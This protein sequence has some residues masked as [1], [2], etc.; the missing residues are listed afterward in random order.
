MSGAS[1]LY[2]SFSDTD[3]S[4]ADVVFIDNIQLSANIGP[5]WWGRIREQPVSLSVYVH[6]R[7]SYLDRAGASDNVRDSVHYG[8]LCKALSVLSK[9]AMGQYFSADGHWFGVHGLARAASNVTFQFAGD[10]AER[11]H[12]VIVSAKLIPLTGEFVFE[13]SSPPSGSSLDSRVR[14]SLRDLVLPAIIGVNPPEREAKQRI[15]TSITVRENPFHPTPVDYPAIVSAVS[16]HIEASAYQTLEKFVLDVVRLVC[17][18]SDAIE[19]VT[20]QAKKPSALS[21]ADAAGVQISRERS[22]FV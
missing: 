13:M 16:K 21:F 22:A 11:V 20:V 15:V 19:G 8:K 2:S 7:P 6:L 17:L 1:P 4:P 12:I 10:A 3:V 5:D 14:V 18:S 9:P